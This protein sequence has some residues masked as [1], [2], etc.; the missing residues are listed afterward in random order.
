V[1]LRIALKLNDNLVVETNIA[2]LRVGG[3]LSLEGSTAEPILFGTVESQEGRITF[4]KHRFTVVSAAARFTDPRRIYPILDVTAAT[5]IR[6]YDVTMR[7]SG[8]PE[9]LLVRLSS[10]PPLDQEDLL[11]LVT[12]GATRS[13]I[14]SSAAGIVAAEAAQL[15]VEDLVGVRSS[16]I[17]L[18]RIEL[19]TVGGQGQEQLRVGARLTEDVKVIYAQGLAGD[20][21]RVLRIEYQ[22]IGP[23][24]LAG[25]QDFQG[26][27]G[28]DLLLRLRMR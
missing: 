7:V 23:L 25:E 16:S 2:R 28:G 8:P 12:L 18:D 17:G 5:R 26:G 14:G 21:R 13:E 10:T 11:T 9:E 22:V 19:G 27:Y 15:L 3:T 24:F 1:P 4:R 6:T 20:S